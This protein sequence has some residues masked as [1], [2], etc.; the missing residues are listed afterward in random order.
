MRLAPLLVA[1]AA[2]WTAAACGTPA[3][4]LTISGSALGA[5][6]IVLRRQVERFAAAHPG[7]PVEIQSTPDA[8]DQRHQLYV[9]WLN[10]WAPDP[11]ILQLDVIWTPEFAAAGWISPLDRFSPS[12]QDFFATAITANRWDD[13]LY[14]MPWFVDVGVFYWRTDLVRAPPA[15][16]DDLVAESLRAKA[17]GRV[18][19]G[20]IW[21]GARY[22]GLVTVFLEHLVGFGGRVLDDEGR[23]VVD[24]PA[25]VRALSFM[26]R[27]IDE[28]KIVPASVLAWQEEQSRFAFQ[29]GQVLF[30]RNWPYA[31]ALIRDDPRSPAAGHFA[32]AAMPHDD[33][34]QSA[35]VLGGAQLAINARSRQPNEAW[36]LIQYLTSPEQMVERARVAGQF[37][38]RRSVYEGS[39]LTDALPMA[40]AEAKELI[41]RAVLRP[42]TPVY[43]QL[44]GILQVHL[45]RAL[46]RQE[47]PDAALSHAAMEMRHLLTKAGLLPTES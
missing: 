18:K 5:E 23:V 40:P 33:S 30:M 16:F 2:L 36:E 42:N 37:P 14:A 39:Q 15:T 12:T 3:D 6:G 20:F 34:G 19:D 41:E 38:S 45:H 11:D 31:A 46:T 32:L 47:E 25:A 4:V 24:S 10:G 8:A 13:R 9:Q 17:D 43:T 26:R 29:N 28:L 35:S 21:Q 27:S 1:A 22:E 44:S 7:L